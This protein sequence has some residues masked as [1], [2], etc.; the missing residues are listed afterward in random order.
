MAMLS[1]GNRVVTA[2][3][4][5]GHRSFIYGTQRGERIA[6]REAEV[7]KE[8]RILG[9]EPRFL[10]LPFYDSNYEV[11]ERDLEILDGAARG[12][13]PRLGLHAA[14]QGQPSRARGEPADRQDSLRRVPGGT[15]KVVEVWNYEGPWALFNRG[16]FN[17][18][19]TVPADRLR[20]QAAGHPRARVPGGAHALR[21]GGGI[22]GP[23]ALGPGARVG[24]GG[25]RRPPAAAGRMDGA[26]FPG[27]RARRAGRPAASGMPRHRGAA[28]CRRT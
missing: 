17:T 2:V 26:F 14:H 21:R 5:T 19:V 6:I 27:D 12:A 8:S 13:G 18:I 24:A 20:A 9:A 1:Q 15:R 22:P 16:E 7:V 28:P 10:R 23:A 25:V 4:S 11:S 3:M